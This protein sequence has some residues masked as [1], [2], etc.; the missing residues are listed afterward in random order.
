MK[1]N[2]YNIFSFS[3]LFFLYYFL[4]FHNNY[5]L[6]LGILHGFFFF[7]LFWDGMNEFKLSEPGKSRLISSTESL[8]SI[9]IKHQ[10]KKK[11]VASTNHMYICPL[12]WATG[13]PSSVQHLSYYYFSPW[14]QIKPIK[15][16]NVEIWASSTQKCK[17]N[18]YLFIYY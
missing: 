18:I 7:F 4:L 13:T 14:E 2:S 3:D 11:K 15:E 5:L 6:E 10:K 17:K 16:Y 1:E 9:L 8:L 12:K